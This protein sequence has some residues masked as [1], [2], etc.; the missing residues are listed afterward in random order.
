M[1]VPQSGL[2]IDNPAWPLLQGL[3]SYWGVTTANGNP[4][5]TTVVDA[6]CST[7]GGQPSYANLPITMLS[8]PSAGQTKTISAHT[9]ATGTLE[10]VDPWTNPAG[11]A[12][13]IVA[14]T[15]FAILSAIGD[16]VLIQDI[17]DLVNAMLVTME[18]GGSITTDGTEQTIYINN[19][20][21]GVYEPLKLMVDFTN[22][23]QAETV[24]IRTYYRI[25]LL[26]ALIKKDEVTF[27]GE[28]DPPLIN[29]ELEPNRY[30][31][32]VTIQRTA[33]AAWVYDWAVFYR[34]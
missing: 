10:A 25:N 4:A 26:G 28:Q 34:R 1:K 22:Q 9:L 13:Q 31:I 12:Q 6:L 18:T 16:T 17:F 29:V 19:A 3:I 27:A 11:A 15:R 21:A 5:G 33:G 23:T 7:A 32:W 2:F 8:G 14:G 24:I 30:G 20:P